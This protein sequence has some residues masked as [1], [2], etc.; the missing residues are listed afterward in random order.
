MPL[1]GDFSF[2]FQNTGSVRKKETDS[3]IPMIFYNTGDMVPI[4]LQ[5]K[6]VIK[7]NMAVSNKS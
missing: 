5:H 3:S 2:G 7:Y 6:C 1:I 4:K